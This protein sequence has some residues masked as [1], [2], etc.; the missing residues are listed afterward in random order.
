[1]SD[2][3][4][5]QPVCPHPE[6]LAIWTRPE[7]AR[8][9]AAFWSSCP[10][11]LEKER[12]IASFLAQVQPASIIDLG[13]G[14]GRLLGYL[15]ASVRSY[16]GVDLSPTLVELAQGRQPQPRQ[17]EFRVG[18][19]LALTGRRRQAEMV[20]L[21]DVLRHYHPATQRAVLEYAALFSR[22]YLI[23]N[24]FWGPREETFGNAFIL[25]LEQVQSLIQ[26]WHILQS[27][28]VRAERWT[29]TIYLAEVE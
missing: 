18:N 10:P 28:D 20:V 23:F 6:A 7:L 11:K 4:D 27:Q 2:L 9:L 13:C 24:L 21:S 22:H 16:F 3:L 19:F 15:P 26:G 14:D 17:C 29:D 12:I 8:E 25:S 5:S 1:M